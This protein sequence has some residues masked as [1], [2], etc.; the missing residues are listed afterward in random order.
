MDSNEIGIITGIVITCNAIVIGLETDLGTGP[1]DLEWFFLAFYVLE[2]VARIVHE[3]RNWCQSVWN[4]ADAMFVLQMAWDMIIGTQFMPQVSRIV[5]RT[6]RILRTFRLLRVCGGLAIMMMA[7]IKAMSE[8]MWAGVFAVL[9]IYVSAV[10]VTQTCGHNAAWWGDDAEQIEEW[11]GT[12]SRS[13]QTLFIIMTLSGWDDVS[14]TLA[15]V[16]PAYIIWPSCISYILLMSYAMTSLITGIISESLIIARLNDEK[17]IDQEIAIARTK[18]LKDLSAAL[19]QLDVTG[20][21]QITRDA[22]SFQL[23][24]YPEILDKLASVNIEL[25]EAQ[26]LSFFDKICRQQAQPQTTAIDIDIFCTNLDKLAGPF[27]AAG[28]FDLKAYIVELEHKTS[29][30]F[31]LLDHKFEELDRKTNDWDQ[32]L[33]QL[34]EMVQGLTKS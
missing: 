25:N 13:M 17:V 27:T 31:N 34:C 9:V 32:K 24:E 7:V 16:M 21:A 15:K 2:L 18:F 22:L 6:V 1:L 10:H 19:K 29:A 8:V 28:Q 33:S 30:R 20:K 23:K 26:C 3:G 4:F 14:R 12:V 11:F 5:F